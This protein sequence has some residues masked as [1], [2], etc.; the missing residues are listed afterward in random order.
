MRTTVILKNGYRFRGK[1]LEETDTILILDEIRLG[2][3][4]IN[5]ASISVRSDG[6]GE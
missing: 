1:I 4:T 2:H 6:G 5:K 3:T